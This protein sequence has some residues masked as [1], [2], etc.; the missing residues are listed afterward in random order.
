[1]NEGVNKFHPWGPG[2]KLRMSL[3]ADRRSIKTEKKIIQQNRSSA[4]LFHKRVQA[5]SKN[6]KAK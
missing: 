3:R 5:A 6:V 2:V 1:V 4:F